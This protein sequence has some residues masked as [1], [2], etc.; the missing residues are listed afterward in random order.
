MLSFLASNGARPTID[1]TLPLDQVAD[2]LAA[3][4]SGDLIGK[5]VIVP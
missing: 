1:R 4:E 2:G 5:I 3:M